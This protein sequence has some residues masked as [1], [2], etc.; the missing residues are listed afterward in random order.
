MTIVY[1]QTPEENRD[2]LQWTRSRQMLLD[3]D[4]RSCAQ[5]RER[6]PDKRRQVVRPSFAIKVWTAALRRESYFQMVCKG[7]KLQGGQSARPDELPEM[8]LKA[9]IASGRRQMT[10]ESF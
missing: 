10:A 3:A 4:S 1:R 8:E 5:W 6:L 9:M 2:L 7:R